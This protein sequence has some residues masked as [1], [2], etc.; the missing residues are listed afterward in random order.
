MKESR[1]FD[2]QKV[3]KRIM[4]FVII[5]GVTNAG[6]LIAKGVDYYI[7]Y[8]ATTAIT[9]GVSYKGVGNVGNFNVACKKGT[10]SNSFLNIEIEFENLSEDAISFDSAITVEAYQDGIQLVGGSMDEINSQLKI[11]PNKKI[12]INQSYVINSKEQPVRV[13]FYLSGCDTPSFVAE[14]K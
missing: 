2:V 12:S 3:L 5:I 11:K 4:I 13:E 8:K 9:E 14:L 6:L 10:L 7:A 1:P